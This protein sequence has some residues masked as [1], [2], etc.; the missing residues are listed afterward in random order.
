[1]PKE[2]NGFPTLKRV[3]FCYNLA[4]LILRITIGYSI[5][6]RIDKL[7]QACFPPACRADVFSHGNAGPVLQWFEYDFR[8]EQGAVPGIS[9]DLL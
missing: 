5:T 4:I 9:L 2:A 8:Q 7:I 1:M 3:D 6:N